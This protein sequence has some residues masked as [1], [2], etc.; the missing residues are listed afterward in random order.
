VARNFVA[1]VK[2]RGNGEPYVLIEPYED[3]GTGSRGIGL[4]LEKGADI[5]AAEDLARTLNRTVSSFRL[6]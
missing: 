3:I 5:S 2:E 1:T 4:R 6:S